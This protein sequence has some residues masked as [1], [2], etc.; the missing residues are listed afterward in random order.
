MKVYTEQEIRRLFPQEP[1]PALWTVIIPAAGKGSRLGYN[2]PKI[3]YPVAGRSILDHMISLLEPRM[4]KFVFAVSPVGAP[5]II[6]ELKKRIPGRFETVI[7]QS[8]GMAD[9]IYQALHHVET[10]FVFIIWGDQVAISDCTVS[11]V[12][13]MAQYMPGAKLTLPLVKRENPYVHYETNERGDF[14]GV[15]EKREG[16]SMPQIGESDCG[17]LSFLARFIEL[18]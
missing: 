11:M 12:Q 9:S 14:S 17:V 13:K 16:A 3:L 2:K 6:P 4:S 8:R 1:D 5:D 15:K 18:K 10:P 7:L